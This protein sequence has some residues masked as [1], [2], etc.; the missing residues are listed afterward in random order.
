MGYTFAAPDPLAR[1]DEAAGGADSLRAPMPGLVKLVRV[2]G[3]EAVK[4]GQAL[5]VLEAMKMEHTIA[6]PHDGIVAEIV[7]EGAQVTDGA[8][9]VRFA[10]DDDSQV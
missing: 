5:L 10:E 2:A 3:G 9:L 7:A 1:A 6:A 4:K 8:V